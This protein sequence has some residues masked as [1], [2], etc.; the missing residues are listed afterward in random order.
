[1]GRVHFYIAHHQLAEVRL[2]VSLHLT[3]NLATKRRI[4]GELRGY[5]RHRLADADADA[6]DVLQ[7]VFLKAMRQDPA[8]PAT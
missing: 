2:C 8:A 1:M 7:D 6:A 4:L 3:I 5:P